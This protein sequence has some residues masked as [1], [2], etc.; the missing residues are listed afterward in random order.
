MTGIISENDW[1]MVSQKSRKRGSELIITHQLKSGKMT[2]THEYRI[3]I[4]SLSMA[5]YES[6][7]LF[8]SFPFLVPHSHKIKEGRKVTY[9]RSIDEWEDHLD[10][11][12]FLDHS[13][14]EQKECIQCQIDFY[15]TSTQELCFYCFKN[16]QKDATSEAKKLCREV[17]KLLKKTAKKPT[18]WH[19]IIESVKDIQG[20]W[21][22]LPPMS[23]T[24]NEKL[25]DRFKTAAQAIFEKKFALNRERDQLREAHREKAERLIEEAKKWAA[26][27]DLQRATDEIKLLQK[28]WKEVHPLPREAADILWE[29]FRGY[30][31]GFFDK[32]KNRYLTRRCP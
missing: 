5:L 22:L 8:H 12:G 14:I 7:L 1:K 13:N 10:Q 25:W 24:D 19:Q 3:A 17:E 32:K 23:Q 2:Q 27:S 4:S 29:Q 26:S 28:K 9:D 15:D 20:K 31:Q 21:K 30:C 16:Q 18:D 6:T 11:K